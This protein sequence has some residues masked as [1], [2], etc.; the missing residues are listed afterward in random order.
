MK[1]LLAG[2]AAAM[3]SL[4][5]GLGAAVIAASGASGSGNAPTDVAVRDI[6]SELLAIYQRAA[7]TCPGLPWPVLAAIGK[8]ESDH[9]R[10]DSATFDARGQVTPWIIGAPLDGTGGTARV[11][12][13]DQGR[14]DRDDVL[15]RAVGPMQFLPSTWARWGV[16][17]SDDGTA[18]P[19]SAMDAV[20]A[21]AAY[22][23]GP[24]R[25]V[26][27]L[28]AALLAYNPSR[29]YLDEV[30]SIARSYGSLSLVGFPPN[31][32]VDR[33]LDSPNLSIVES[34][35]IDLESGLVDPRVVAML[36]TV[37]KHW[38]V[39]VGVIRTGHSQCV[40]GGSRITRPSCPVSDHWY[41]RGVDIYAVNGEPVTAGN[42]AA[43]DLALFL[44]AVNPP[45][46]PDSLGLPW[47]ELTS[48]PGVFSDSQHLDHLHVSWAEPTRPR[49][50][51]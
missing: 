33:V 43:L 32:L 46:R 8:V 4:P 45:L 34:A 19:H 20:F 48:L 24:D 37:G 12:D 13:T 9:A 47:P 44:V 27:D 17:A 14:W 51:P 22:L 1:V 28:E 25:G 42:R 49:S 16:D 36:T 35:R 50:T 6:P 31:A 29:A 30:L 39:G 5:V 7:S 10:E 15:D 26:E 40:G 21:A 38:K 2:G 3:L 11:A 41:G 18:N 23:C